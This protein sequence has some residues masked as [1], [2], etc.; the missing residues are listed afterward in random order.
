MEG[1]PRHL[2]LTDGELNSK[3]L[4]SQ[5]DDHFLRHG[6]CALPP[7][8]HWDRQ[9]QGWIPERS[10]YPIREPPTNFGLLQETSKK[11]RAKMSDDL[12][13][14]YADSYRLPPR[15]AMTF[16]RFAVAPR[17]LSSTTHAP[18]NLCKD[19]ELKAHRYLQVPDHGVK[20]ITEVPL[21]DPAC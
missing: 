15:S 14:V 18:N 6:N 4:V 8:R 21:I 19:L 20:I 2:L 9:T 12:K 17:I 5:Y 1:L 7:L 11:W 3:N 13:S 16:P 10:D